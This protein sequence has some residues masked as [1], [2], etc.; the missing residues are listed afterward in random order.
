MEG[1]E[2]FEITDSYFNWDLTK[3]IPGKVLALGKN[4][5]K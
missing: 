5:A 3:A 2:V 4:A 1:K